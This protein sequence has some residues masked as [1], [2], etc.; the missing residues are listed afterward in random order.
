MLLTC[1]R[2]RRSQAAK[3]TGMLRCSASLLTLAGV[4]FFGEYGKGKFY[5]YPLSNC[6]LPPIIWP[7]GEGDADKQEVMRATVLTSPTLNQQKKTEEEDKSLL[8]EVRQDS[9]SFR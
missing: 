4:D 9:F 7:R 6:F 2:F 5:L 1:L 3:S 8:E